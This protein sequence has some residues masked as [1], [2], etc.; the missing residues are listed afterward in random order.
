MKTKVKKKTAKK[1]STTKN[2]LVRLYGFAP[3]DRGAKVR[4]LLNEMGV[5]Y[6]DR[7][8]DPEKNEGKS[9][10]FL[11]LNPM[12]RVPVAEIGDVVLFESG[13]ICA[14]LSDLYL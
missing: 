5:K 1:N 9:P 10:S 12:G 13:A 7:W 2:R 11:K 14:Y 3:F 8:M 6:E 4:W